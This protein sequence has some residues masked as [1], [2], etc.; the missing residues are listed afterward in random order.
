MI[1]APSMTAVV[2][3]PGM[4]SANIGTIAPVAAALLAASGAATP[5]ITPVPNFSGCF[6]TFFSV[7]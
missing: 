5:S 2:P 3:E 6:E 4:P 7:A 1:S